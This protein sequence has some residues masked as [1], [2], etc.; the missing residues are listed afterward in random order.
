MHDLPKT[1]I[2]RGVVTKLNLLETKLTPKFS[3]QKLKRLINSEVDWWGK[4]GY[5]VPDI[6]I[7]EARKSSMAY[8]TDDKIVNITKRGL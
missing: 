5:A 6:N 4:S 2:Y 8:M 7:K 1:F 3:D